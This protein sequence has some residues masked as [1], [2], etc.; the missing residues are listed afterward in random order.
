MTQRRQVEGAFYDIF[1]EL[2]VVDSDGFCKY[3]RMPHAKFW[4]QVKGSNGIVDEN[5]GKFDWLLY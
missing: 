5:I 2:S 3:M 1:P 4:A